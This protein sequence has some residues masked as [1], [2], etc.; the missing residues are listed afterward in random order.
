M[1]PFAQR[2]QIGVVSYWHRQAHGRKHGVFLCLLQLALLLFDARSL[3]F[4]RFSVT[5]RVP[6]E[7]LVLLPAPDWRHQRVAKVVFALRIVLDVLP[8]ELGAAA[9]VVVSVLQYKC[10]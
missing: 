9:A 1:R 7:I 4:F 2:C 6:G 5:L 10:S 8:L 3:G